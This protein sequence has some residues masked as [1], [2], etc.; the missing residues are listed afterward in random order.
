MSRQA[1]HRAAGLF[2]A[3]GDPTRVALVRRLGEG[4]ALSATALA[5]DAVLTRQAIT[6]HLQ[7][8]AGAG[9]VSSARQGREVLYALESARLAE[10]R[11]FLEAASRRW[12]E[13]IARLR[14]LVEPPPRRAAR[15]RPARGG[16]RR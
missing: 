12:D 1:D 7:V 15:R 2:A 5:E 10:A 4:D 13:A 16:R 9:L 3:L 14:Q 6:K 11:A 8:L